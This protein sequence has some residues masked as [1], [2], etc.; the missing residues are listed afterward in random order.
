MRYHFFPY[1]IND[2]REQEI[3]VQNINNI[4]IL[5]DKNIVKMFQEADKLGYETL[6]SELLDKYFGN[7]K[8]EVVEYL[9][10]KKL[11]YEEEEYKENV[12]RVNIYTNDDV[13]YES[14][15][16]NIENNLDVN[17]S[18]KYRNIYEL[19][20]EDFDN[21]DN[22][23]N[24]IVLN[25]FN[26]KVYCMLVEKIMKYD[27]IFQLI[28]YYNS[29]FYF[30]NYYRT[31]LKN[32]CPICFFSKIESELRAEAK[33]HLNSYQIIIDLIYR[34]KSM[35]ETYL[36]M[37]RNIALPIINLVNNQINNIGNNSFKNVNSLDIKTGKIET[38]IAIH[39]ELCE[40]N[41]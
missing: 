18:F 27:S 16:F 15:I 7:D 38:D 3:I 13:I 2:F 36:K 37:K 22:S 10:E 4:V 31:V 19:L 34:K 33:I 39:W 25:P 9:I 35:F 28:F 24:I 21:I 26:Y 20:E 17:I 5:K 1:I 6:D 14:L 11:I 30:S 40:C 12:K 29:K 8:K 41:D 23:L 32:P